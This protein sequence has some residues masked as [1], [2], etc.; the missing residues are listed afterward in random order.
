MAKKKSI[1]RDPKRFKMI[2]PIQL[3]TSAKPSRKVLTNEEI[4]ER[5]DDLTN[6]LIKKRC[7][8]KAFETSAG[9]CTDNTSPKSTLVDLIV[10]IDTSGSMSDE[11]NELSISANAAIQAAAV[12]C[13]SDLRV[14]WFGIEGTWPGTNFVQTYRSYLNALGFTALS[15]TPSDQEDGAA[16]IFDLSRHY[17]WRSGAKRLIFYLGDEAMEAGDP[18]DASDV[19]ATDAAIGEAQAQSVNVYTYLGTGMADPGMANDYTRLATATGGQAFAAPAANLGGFQTVLQTVICD[20]TKEDGCK[21]VELPIIMPCF[22][23]SWGDGA[24][25]HIETNDSEVICITACNPYDNVTIKDLT[26]H[27]VVQ[28]CNGNSIPTLPDGM[29]SVSITPDLHI[30]FGD[31]KPCT[32]ESMKDGSNCVAREVCIMT[33]GAI[34]QCYQ[35]VVVSCFETCFHTVMSA[36][37]FRFDLVKS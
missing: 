20:G 37:L 21:T 36:P 13:P 12:S 29:P 6:D 34:E 28:D 15:G 35:I 32:E 11:A 10:L 27:L 31:L 2:E 3:F 33:C 25:D 24:N 23:F 9:T 18:Q 19:S 30:C 22:K 16:A 7:M 8:T 1:K 17:D 14:A 5:L 26:I 4:C